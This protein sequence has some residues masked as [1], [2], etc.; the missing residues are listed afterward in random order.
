M[1][2]TS[3]SP[4]PAARHYRTQAT[5]L[6]ALAA[7]AK[8]PTAKAEYLRIAREYEQLADQVDAQHLVMRH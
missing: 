3:P 1:P 7:N 5:E 8:S 2:A 4:S 6:R